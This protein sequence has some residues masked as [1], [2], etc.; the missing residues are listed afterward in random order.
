MAGKESDGEAAPEMFGESEGF[1]HQKNG[2]SISKNE[3]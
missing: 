2:D 1:S 3:G